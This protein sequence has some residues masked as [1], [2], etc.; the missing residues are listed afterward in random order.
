[1]Q[2]LNRE[3]QQQFGEKLNKELERMT[4]SWDNDLRAW[5]P[6]AIKALNHVSCIQLR[7]DQALYS[8]LFATESQGINMNIVGILADNLQARKP[9][10]MGYAAEDWQR[11]LAL[12]NRVTVRW[13]ELVR[14]I[15]QRIIKEI[16]IMSN[17]PGLIVAQA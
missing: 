3:Q 16:Q 13:N 14:P 9:Y 12:N 5:H 17:K 1:M 7:V 10:E 6:T 2:Q 15:E 4:M 11:V 8:T